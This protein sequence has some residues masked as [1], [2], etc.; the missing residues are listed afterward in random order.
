[1]TYSSSIPSRD[2]S[3]PLVI[4]D[5][6][7]IKISTSNWTSCYAQ[8]NR[9]YAQTHRGA[10][11]TRTFRVWQ[12][13]RDRWEFRSSNVDD[14]KASEIHRSTECIQGKPEDLKIFMVA[15]ETKDFSSKFRRLLATNPTNP[16]L[17]WKTTASSCTSLRVSCEAGDG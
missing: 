1:M 15:D 4:H 7:L 6:H 14:V 11:N 16:Y 12:P 5:L 8:S 2:D 3:I 9:C 17:L 10:E 13:G